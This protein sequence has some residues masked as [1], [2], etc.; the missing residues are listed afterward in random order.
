M[1]NKYLPLLTPGKI[2]SLVLKNRIVFPPMTTQ[3][4]DIQGN[5][6]GR[7]IDYY[8]RRARGGAAM[9]TTDACFPDDGTQD[10]CLTFRFTGDRSKV[11]LN[12]LCQTVHA[13]GAKLCVQLSGGTG[14]VG[15]MNKG[16]LPKSASNIP[17]LYNPSMLCEEMTKDEIQESL[18][19]I[20]DV[21]KNLKQIGV[22]AVNIH[23][24]N[25]YLIDQFMSPQW[26]KRSDEYGGTMENRMRFPIELI[27][28]LK[29]ALGKD[30]PIIFR[31]SVDQCTPGFRTLEDTIPMLRLLEEA[32]V[33]ALDVDIGVYECMDIMFPPYYLGDTPYRNA[34]KAVKEAGI[35][36]PVLNSG[37]Y[38]A[39]K[40]LDAINAGDVDFV[41]FG[42]PM[43]A[44]PD[45][46]NHL[47]ANAPE[48]IKPCI[49]C[50]DFCLRG[51][52]EKTGIACAVNAQA[53][54][55]RR[56]TVYKAET[57]QKI[58]IVGGGPAGMEAALVAKQKGHDVTLY[59]KASSLGGMITAA[60]TPPFKSQLKALIDWYVIQL[61]KRAVKVCLNSEITAD[62]PILADADSIII[63]TGSVEFIPSIPGIENAVRIVNAHHV[64][65]LVKGDKVIVAGGG[66]SGCDFAVEYAMEGKKVTVVEMLDDVARDMISVNAIALKKKLAQYNIEVLTSH[67]ITAFTKGGIIAEHD[68]IEKELTA[69]T[70]VI[71]FGCKPNIDGASAIQ[72]KY[73]LKTRIIGD[74]NKIGKAGEA[75][76]EGFF[77]ANV[78]S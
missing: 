59:E 51:V 19:N 77:A 55:E 35:K 74:A 60:A 7:A 46:A 42:R 6:S 10:G 23:A 66:L 12:E 53:G 64:P 56:N 14:R 76:R 21:A 18:A 72:N 15:P 61:E 38:T 43:I 73:P 33:D 40:A 58:A 44:E 65:E 32:G 9:I 75:I 28:A 3:L 20:V 41:M 62:S 5:Y 30:F 4:N 16:K 63:A 67:K 49:R 57:P 8:E 29:E 31:I 71:A 47:M 26:N 54:S 25:G 48:D 70:V 39:D 50:N 1:E 17:W 45:L 68:G 34:A 11:C 78:I 37:N 2:G 36:V 22:D 52:K 13:Y 69:D 27:K 24:H